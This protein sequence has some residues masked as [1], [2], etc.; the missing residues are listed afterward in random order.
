[1]L[2]GGIAPLESVMGP[3]AEVL[4]AIVACA[5]HFGATSGVLTPEHLGESAEP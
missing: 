4:V 2:C 1:M 3:W 5:R